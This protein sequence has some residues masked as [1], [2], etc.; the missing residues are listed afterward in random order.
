MARFVRVQ[1]DE[2][3]ATYDVP[4]K[5]EYEDLIEKLRGTQKDFETRFWGIAQKI[6]SLEGR[7]AGPDNEKT[8][9]TIMNGQVYTLELEG[10]KKQIEVFEAERQR[11]RYASL[12][13]PHMSFVGIVKLA[14]ECGLTVMNVTTYK[15]EDK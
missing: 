8:Q 5:E 1:E 3:Y 13:P 7:I 2:S 11:K 4:T 15:K 6:I 10:T 14:L 9:I 12:F